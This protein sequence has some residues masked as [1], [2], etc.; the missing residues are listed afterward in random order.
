MFKVEVLR[1][2]WVIYS[3]DIPKSLLASNFLRCRNSRSK[4]GR[5]P[6]N[7]GYYSVDHDDLRS[8]M[9]RF[10]MLR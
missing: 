7:P 9:L 5:F 10:A 3:P 8:P 4:V 1:R 6:G 2:S